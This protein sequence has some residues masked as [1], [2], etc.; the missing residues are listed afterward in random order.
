ML[1]SLVEWEMIEVDPGARNT[2]HDGLLEVL[3][4]DFSHSEIR[5]AQLQVYIEAQVQ[6]YI[7]VQ[8]QV[9]IEAR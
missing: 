6:V 7:E 4:F 8:L 9:N 2:L 1:T 5:E 3:L